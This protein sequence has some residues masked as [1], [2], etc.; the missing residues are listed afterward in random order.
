VKFGTH[1][2]PL[3]ATRNGRD[4]GSGL[5]VLGSGVFC[6]NILMGN[7]YK[8]PLASSRGELSVSEPVP[9]ICGSVAL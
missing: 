8:T 3:A 2:R 9:D 4:P 1:P 5:W 7:S 6:N